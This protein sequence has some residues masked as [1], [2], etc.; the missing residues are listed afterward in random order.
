MLRHRGPAHWCAGLP[1]KELEEVRAPIA[2]VEFIAPCCRIDVRG[3]C[4]NPAVAAG[5]CPGRAIGRRTNTDLSVH[6]CCI[7]AVVAFH[8]DRRHGGLCHIHCAGQW[9]RARGVAG[10]P[11]AGARAEQRHAA[12]RPRRARALTRPPSARLRRIEHRHEPEPH[13]PVACWIARLPRRDKLRSGETARPALRKKVIC[14]LAQ[15]GVQ[16]PPWA[17]VGP[18]ICAP[19]KSF[20]RH[21]CSPASCWRGSP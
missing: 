9:R 10:G 7:C 5:P 17:Q 18:I 21:S 6:E 16:A 8:V 19:C 4:H 11:G 13:Q 14:L 12:S 15:A 2:P 1:W 3:A 20:A